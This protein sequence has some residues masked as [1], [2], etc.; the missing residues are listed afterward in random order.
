[1]IPL[2]CGHMHVCIYMSVSGR[3]LA[4]DEQGLGWIHWGRGMV[5]NARKKPPV[6][7]GL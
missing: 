2:V 4:W 6:W 3:G 7:S 5:K 1:M